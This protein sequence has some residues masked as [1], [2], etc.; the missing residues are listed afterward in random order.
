MKIYFSILVSLL[1]LD[2]IWLVF[3]ASAFYKK[4]LGYIFAETFKLLPAGIFYVLYAFG[5]AYFVVNP[6]VEAK[7]FMLAIGRGAFLGLLA[8]GAYDLTNHATL[9]RWPTIVTIVDLMWG[10]FVTAAASA[11][12]YLI[13]TR[14]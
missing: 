1:T 4:Y 7:S 2:G 8:Y 6:A 14:T 13:A 5:I 9:A 12:A 10:V 3:V 11:V